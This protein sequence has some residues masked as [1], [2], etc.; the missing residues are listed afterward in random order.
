MKKSILI[1]LAIVI[2]GIQ[3][4]QIET[5]STPLPAA[6]MKS[7]IPVPQDVQSILKKSCS[8]C[9]SQQTEYPWY[10]KI[11]PIGWWINH[12]IEEGRMEF[13]MDQFGNYPIKRQEHLLE[14]IVEV[15][16]SGEMPM[17][18]YVLMHP[19][20]KLSSS[21]KKLLTDWASAS[22]KN[23]ASEPEED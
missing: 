22:I 3:F 11:Q 18:S 23:G 5:H 2:V 17:S 21:E 4:F 19:K 12:H 10:T 16:E 20:S 6:P 13:N 15:V 7:V 14:E 9:H 8:D 1:I